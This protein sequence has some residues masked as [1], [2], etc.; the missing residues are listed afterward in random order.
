MNDGEEQTK[1]KTRLIK[2]DDERA[3]NGKTEVV[4]L[5]V[6]NILYAMT[7]AAWYKQRMESDGNAEMMLFN[8]RVLLETF[9]QKQSL[10]LLYV[11]YAVRF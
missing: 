8:R 7:P 6:M 5:W 1:L 10:H 9:E 3:K 11:F 2:W 4:W